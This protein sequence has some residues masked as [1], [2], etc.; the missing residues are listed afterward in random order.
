MNSNGFSKKQAM[1]DA[2]KR[3]MESKKP[4]KSPKPPALP[5]SQVVAASTQE[6]K[7]PNPRTS[8]ARDERSAK[9][10]RLPERTLVGATF[11]GSG[12][13]LGHMT[14]WDCKGNG[15]IKT[16]LHEADGLF[17]LMEELDIQ[18]WNWFATKVDDE[19]KAKLVFLSQP[20]APAPFEFPQEPG[21][22]A[23]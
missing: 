7:K 22:A 19:I 11:D 4:D 2:I 17:R 14:L 21:P 18:F 3:H 13:W 23:S 20:P 15:P 8:R 16:F 12:Q 1:Q 6:P 10:G 5:K 9:R